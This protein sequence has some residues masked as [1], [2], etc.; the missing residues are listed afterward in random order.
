[1][2]VDLIPE[3]VGGIHEATA[4]TAARPLIGLLRIFCV[5]AIGIATIG[6]ATSRALPRALSDPLVAGRTPALAATAASAAQESVTPTVAVTFDDLPLGGPQFGLE[7]MESMTD[8]LV[9]SIVE[10]GVPAIGFVNESKIDVDGERDARTELL[11]TWADA[12]LELGNHTYSHPSPHRV[13]LEQYFDDIVRGEPI[14]RAVMAEQGAELRYFRHPFLFRGRTP[15]DKA[16]IDAFLAERGYTIAPV[17]MDNADYI[18]SALYTA[19]KTRGD[20]ALMERITEAYLDFSDA[21]YQFYEEAAEELFGRPIAHVYLLHANELNADAFPRFAALS[22]ARGYRF[23]TLE[24]ALRDPAY[25]TGDHYAGPA[26]TSWLFR[27]DATQAQDSGVRAVDWRTE[28]TVQDWVQE[29]F[30]RRR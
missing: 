26:G 28:P 25:E 5:G 19:A 2:S 11:R 17:T 27:W 24:E 30:D 7:R 20:D 23:V 3:R 12:G 15:E 29:A 6:V 4:R 16:A 8:R 18:Y 21:V 9:A 13:P 1:V 22:R 14:T 10:E